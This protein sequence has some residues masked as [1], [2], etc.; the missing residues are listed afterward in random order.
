MRDL[1]LNLPVANPVTR[2][3]GV[4][5]DRRTCRAYRPSGHHWAPGTLQAPRVPGKP[6]G[7]IV[8]CL[9][10]SFHAGQIPGAP[11]DPRSSLDNLE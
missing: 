5:A 1:N 8:V 6:G 3:V 7:H 10:S 11:G 9:G 2:L 4:P